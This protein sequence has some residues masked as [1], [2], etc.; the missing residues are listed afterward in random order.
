MFLEALGATIGVEGLVL[1]ILARTLYARGLSNISVPRL[2]LIAFF[3][4]FATIPYLWFLLPY[5]IA[6]YWK[7]LVFGEIGVWLVETIF[8]R[9]VLVA[10]LKQAALISLICNTVSVCVGWIIF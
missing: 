2:F 10:D 7:L 5:F 8:Y 6:T 1:L 9:L 3:T 4:S